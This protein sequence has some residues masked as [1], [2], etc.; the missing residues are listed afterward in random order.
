MIELKSDKT[1]WLWQSNGSHCAHCHVTIMTIHFYSLFM[2]LL[3][4]FHG[5]SEIELHQLRLIRYQI[6]AFNIKCM[7]F[8]VALKKAQDISYEKK[9]LILFFFS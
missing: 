9:N 3:L 6:C 2:A 8:A 5:D 4:H 1:Y 7:L